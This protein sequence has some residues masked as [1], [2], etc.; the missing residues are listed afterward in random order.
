MYGRGTEWRL[1]GPG[2]DA[3]NVVGK[4]P[5]V[6]I[7]RRPVTA[8]THLAVAPLCTSIYE[9]AVTEAR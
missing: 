1:T 6:T 7:E 4:S 8:S 2:L 9:F 3:A 5:A